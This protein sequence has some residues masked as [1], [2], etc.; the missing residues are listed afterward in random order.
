MI[1]SSKTL[2][3]THVTKTTLRVSSVVL[4]VT[5]SVSI[6]ETMPLSTVQ[7]SLSTV[8][9]V[10][11]LTPE[12]SSSLSK[13]SST[14]SASI[15]PVRPTANANNS[16]GLVG[17]Q[18]LVPKSE[19]EDIESFR[20]VI[21]LRLAAAYRWGVNKGS[22]RKKRDLE[23]INKKRWKTALVK[24]DA[25]RELESWERSASYQVYE[26]RGRRFRRQVDNIV[27]LVR[28]RLFYF[29]TKT[30]FL[31]PVFDLSN[32]PETLHQMYTIWGFNQSLKTL[33]SFML[34][35]HYFGKG[36]AYQHYTAQF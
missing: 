24:L 6:S 29:N 30:L 4:D 14:A 22:A 32:F 28:S 7:L 2:R 33:I 21:E 5:S 26:K 27:V 3:P 9:D 25:R 31:F 36:V 18:L 23:W 10:T 20:G 35:H 1:T 8:K 11:S 16:E 34:Q 13:T 19:D 15:E 17:I 12:T